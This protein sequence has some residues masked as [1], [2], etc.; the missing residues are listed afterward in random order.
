[1]NLFEKIDKIET[2]KK[3]MFIFALYVFALTIIYVTGGTKYSYTHIIYIPFFLCSVLFKMI[4]GILGSLISAGTLAIMPVNTCTLEMQSFS[5]WFTRLIIFIGFGYISG[6]ISKQAHKDYQKAKKSS[7]HNELGIPNG[8]A[9]KMEINKCIEQNEDFSIVIIYIENKFEIDNT[10]GYSK[11]ILTLR[12]ITGFFQN[13]ITCDEI[14]FF[15][16][17]NNYK[18]LLKNFSYESTLEWI[19]IINS[20]V[21]TKSINIEDFIIFLKTKI[22]SAVFD[23]SNISSDEIIKNAFIAM[24]YS[25]SNYKDFYIYNS[26]IE[27]TFDFTTLISEFKQGIINHDLYIEYQPKLNL[28]SNKVY[29]I[30]ALIRWKHKKYGM[31]PPS[32]FIPQLEKTNYI[33][34]LTYWILENVLEDIKEWIKLGLHLKVSVNITPRN[35]EDENFSE[36]LLNFIKENRPYSQDIEFEMTETDI[37]KN[38]ESYNILN[39]FKNN[40][41]TFAID[42]FGTGYSSL[43]YFKRIPA[44]YIKIDRVFIKEILSNSYD[45][46]IVTTTIKL[47]HTFG[48]LV[49][50]EGVEDIET[51]E[52]LRKIGCDEIQGY[53]YA[54]PMIKNALVDFLRI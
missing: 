15:F 30:E 39:R 20:D 50:A 52:F 16:S 47:A 44:D 37:M 40:G 18:F 35:I 28:I 29:G 41:I 32:N 11:S 21:S 23:K 45:K 24:D 42:D 25:R 9:F 34:D 43:A 33:N 5:N 1:M 31:I 27:K 2:Y 14:K 26:D 13:Y 36:K 6:F 4:G 10:V 19:K 22:G 7:Y 48:K 8:N 51:L 38:F 12:T 46:E 49:I 3:I 17:E 54:K 53:F